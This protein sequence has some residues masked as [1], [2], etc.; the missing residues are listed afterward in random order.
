MFSP[1][2]ISYIAAVFSIIIAISIAAG[3]G[4]NYA[5][6]R[7]GYVKNI[8]CIENKKIIK[9]DIENLKQSFEERSTLIQEKTDNKLSKIHEKVNETN[10][11]VSEINGFLKAHF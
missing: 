11:H 4:Y 5:H 2:L 9:N 8:S 1:G 7:N 6:K 3:W 10:I